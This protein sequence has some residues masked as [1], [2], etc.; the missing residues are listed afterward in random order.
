MTQNDKQKANGDEEVIKEL[1]AANGLSYEKVS[2]EGGNVLALEMFFSGYP[3][4]VGLHLFP[5]LSQLTVVG[6]GVGRIEGLDSC[7]LLQELWIVE[8]QLT[9][10]GGLQACLQLKK[11]FLYDNKIT[12]IGNLEMLENLEVLWLNNNLITVIEGLNTLKNLRELNVAGNAIEKIGCCLDPNVALETLNL[13]GNRISSFKEVA[14]LARLPRLKDLGLKDPQYIPNPVCLLCN[15]ATHVLYHMPWLQRLDTYD[16][17]HKQI[18]DAAE[19]TVMKKMMYYN[20]RVK[21]VQRHLVNMQA[22]LREQKMNLLHLPKERIRNLSFAL[23]NLERELSDVQADF[24]KPC[25]MGPAQPSDSPQALSEGSADLSCKPGDGT[26]GLCL[27]QQ[28]LLKMDAVKERISVWTR[29]LQEI[30][31]RYQQDVKRAAE[32]TGL[33]VHFLLIELE[34]VGNIRF[35]EGSSADTWFNPCCDLILSRFCAWD[36]KA[37]GITG[38]KINQIIRIHNRVLRL[39]FE[40]KLH[41]LLANEES[42][43][44]SQ[45]YKRGLEY[46]FYVSDPEHCDEKNELLSIP[47]NGFKTADSYKALGRERA[48][49]LSNSLSVCD[50]LRMRYLQSQAKACRMS[51][52]DPVPFRYGQIVVAKAFLGRSVSARHGEAVDPDNYPKAHSVFRSVTTDREQQSGTETQK[53]CSSTQHG[54]CDCSLRQSEWFVF[55]HELV[56][57]EYLID[58][59]YV[60]Q[61]L[62]PELRTPYSPE[63]RPGLESAVSAHH[64]HLDEEAL[65]MEPVLKPKPKMISLDEKTMLTV[66]RANV[67]SQ[68]TVLNLHGNSL[69]K[70]KDVSR[71]TALRKLTISFNEFTHLDD[72]SHLPNLEYVDASHNRI[73][74]LEGLRGVS[75]LKHLDLSWNQL[76]R[77]REEAAVL[78][79]HAPMLLRLDIQHNPWHR[80]ESVRMTILGRL[81]TL[82]QLDGRLV[83]EEEAVVSVQMA[84]GC[85]INQAALLA[86]SR[87][88]S[89]RPRRL[90]LLSA[91]QLSTQLSPSPWDPSGELEPGWTSRITALNLDGQKLTRLA[92]LDKL[93]NLQWASFSDNDISKIEGLDSCLH[94]EELCLDGNCIS[95]LDGISKLTRLTR[96]SLNGNQ[97]LTLDEAVLE[98]LPHLHFLSVE[99]NKI[100]SLQGLHQARALIELYAGNNNIGTGWD[101]YHLKGL[102]NLFILDLYGN[103][104]ISKQENYRIFVIFHLPS[105]K[106]LDGI[107]VEVSES[108]HAKDVF[109]GRLTADMVAEK[110][111]HSNYTEISELCLPSLAIRTVDL[112]PADLFQNLWSVNLEHNNLTSFSGLVFLPNLKVLCLNHNR[113]ESILPKQKLQTHL[114]NRQMLYQKVTSSGYGQQGTSKVCR[115]QATSNSLN[116]LMGSLEVLHLSH[117]GISSLAHLQLSRLTNLKALFLQGNEICQIE[118]LEGLCCL[119]ELV[120]DRNRIRSVGEASFASQAALVELHLEENRIRELGQFQG[121]TELRRLF[122][123]MNKIQDVSELEKLE[124]LPSLTELSVV[125][126]PVARKSLHRPAVVLRLTGLQVLDG[127]AVTLEERARAELLC[128]ETQCSPST[129][130]ALDLCVPG[131][132]PLVAR[133]APLRGTNL[134]LPGTLHHFLGRH[135]HML[136]CGLED[137]LP[138]DTHRLLPSTD[139]KQQKHNSGL[140]AVHSRSIH[141]ELAYRQT[142]GL[143]G[144]LHPSSLLP[145]H[146]ARLLYPY[147][148]SQ[149]QD[150]RFQ[151]HS[152]PRPPQM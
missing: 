118:G 91:A 102:T 97:L 22:K 75:K 27:G 56:L 44:F 72:I 83:T 33:M 86:H 15:Y 7:P 111:G 100:G 106:A 131:L 84:A 80:P 82:T 69:N 137:A 57:P 90:S 59:E 126:N 42:T 107:A 135:D 67:L 120:L 70:L 104:L 63:D 16:V 116:P 31:T 30:E 60:T 48:V 21:T 46:L 138:H 113:I 78:R 54:P 94:L 49:P 77:A 105:L 1:C 112:A 142:R 144:N 23:K 103:P 9:E 130:A 64:I 24:R 108:E 39:M 71:L 95:S 34:T 74:A 81:K 128:A 148:R 73:V 98:K 45:N 12:K 58:F 96:L 43:I 11:L 145:H 146:P 47:E 125:G 87:T 114:N 41:C 129:S 36:F 55:D 139:K 20:M 143:G 50:K 89:A 18:K 119:R 4:M 92:N 28:P 2:A 88:D 38:I 6:Q 133:A 26:R 68:I 136:P 40:D 117:N 66:A 17:T 115:D 13:S 79:K 51:G 35:E 110:L 99:S 53:P 85:R 61:P 152:A 52:T 123:G 62:F 101:I 141:S 29:K 3:R 10:I 134:P 122:L 151:S 127:A 109:G 76:T 5:R 19:L 124:V 150:G 14:H 147:P 65:S 37:F 93:V 32:S 8:C 25:G 140:L 121:L 132:L 149:E